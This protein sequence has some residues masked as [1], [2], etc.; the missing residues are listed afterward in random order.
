MESH[1]SSVVMLCLWP[2]F[3]FVAYLFVRLNIKH[4]QKL[5]RLEVFEKDQ[6]ISTHG[7]DCSCPIKT[8]TSRG[9]VT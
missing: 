6:Q 7:K 2:L 9:S 3:I 8:D 4:F 1:I 5:E